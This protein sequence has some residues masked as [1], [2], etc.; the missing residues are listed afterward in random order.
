MGEDKALDHNLSHVSLGFGSFKG[1]NLQ[2]SEILDSPM[3]KKPHPNRKNQQSSE[4]IRL[5]KSSSLIKINRASIDKKL[6]P[7][8][9][10]ERNRQQLLE[11]GLF[12]SQD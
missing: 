3:L 4:K 5:K 8:Q 11:S 1:D 7:I 2:E 6:E 9:I 12:I 10:P